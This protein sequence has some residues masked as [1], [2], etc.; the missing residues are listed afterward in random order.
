MLEQIPGM[1]GA[2]EQNFITDDDGK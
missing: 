2:S 1:I